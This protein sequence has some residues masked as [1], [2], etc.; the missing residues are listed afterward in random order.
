MWEI[1]VHTRESTPSKSV[2]LAHRWPL[3]GCNVIAEAELRWPFLC[4]RSKIHKWLGMLSYVTAGL[5]ILNIVNAPW[6]KFNL[7]PQGQ[8]AVRFCM[9]QT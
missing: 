4:R 5:T 6:G 8:K 1:L 9:I 3:A 7:G 2:V